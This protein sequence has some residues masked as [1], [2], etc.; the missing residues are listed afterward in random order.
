MR[1]L[2]RCLPDHAYW[3]LDEPLADMARAR[4]LLQGLAERTGGD[5]LSPAQCLRLPNT[6][7]TKP[8]RNGQRCEIRLFTEVRYPLNAFPP[9]VSI[10]RREP[11]SAIQRTT[12]T[13]FVPSPALM[14]AV[15]QTFAGQGYRPAGEW[16][17][18]R[19]P[20]PERHKH[21]DRHAS[22]AFNTRTGYG[23]CHVCGTLLLKDLCPVLGISPS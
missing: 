22:F 19:C 8:G 9:A 11:R 5:R 16:L 18:G 7:N 15:T 1:W 20:F 12:S 10:Q 6:I 4:E 17:K 3:W 21:G 23:F 2:A 13:R 14:D